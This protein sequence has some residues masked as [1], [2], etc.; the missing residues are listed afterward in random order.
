MK[1]VPRIYYGWE[2]VATSF[3]TLFLSVGIRFSFGV[4]YVAILP[5][6]P[7]KEGKNL[8]TIHP[9][10]RSL[11]LNP[12]EVHSKRLS[13]RLPPLAGIHSSSPWKN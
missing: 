12:T 13:R 2:I 6:P 1:R 4:F 7:M 11:L 5:I 10:V 9:L 8:M 3:L